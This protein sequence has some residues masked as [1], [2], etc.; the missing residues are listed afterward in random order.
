MIVS[1]MIWSY[2]A[3]S[4]WSN[5]TFRILLYISEYIATIA[6]T[7]STPVFSLGLGV[8][9]VSFRHFINCK[10]CTM[11]LWLLISSPFM[12]A[13]VL[14]I[15]ARNGTM[16]NIDIW[17]TMENV[18]QKKKAPMRVD[19]KSAPELVDFFVGWCVFIWFPTIQ[20][21]GWTYQCV[22]DSKGGSSMIPGHVSWMYVCNVYSVYTWL[23]TP[24]FSYHVLEVRTFCV[25]F[26]SMSHQTCNLPQRKQDIVLIK[27]IFNERFF[28]VKKNSG[29]VMRSCFLNYNSSRWDVMPLRIMRLGSWL[30]WLVGGRI[31]L[32]E[33]II[34]KTPKTKHRPKRKNTHVFQHLPA[35]GS[36]STI[37]QSVSCQ[38]FLLLVVMIQIHA[39]NKQWHI[40][41]PVVLLL[42][43]L[44]T[45]HTRSL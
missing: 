2:T 16:A 27:N 14:A 23:Y 39:V 26:V 11:D 32:A 43:F 19:Q 25:W 40:F 13:W 9:V 38:E 21:W 5:Y 42:K 34:P 44:R 17:K 28:D 3:W 24:I 18:P 8:L 37:F 20:Q 22:R 33:F 4:R 1:H 12:W 35:I 31:S 30:P 6:T 10:R 29:G 45:Y 41:H 7:E 15:A 36:S